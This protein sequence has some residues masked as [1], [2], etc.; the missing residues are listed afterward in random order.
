MGQPGEDPA[1]GGVAFADFH[2]DEE[3]A[4]EELWD[5]DESAAGDGGGGAEACE[6]E[7]ACEDGV[8]EEAV[9]E[10]GVWGEDWRG[11]GGW[12]GLWWFCEGVESPWW[13]GEGEGIGKV[14]HGWWWELLHFFLYVC[15]G[16]YYFYFY[17][18]DGSFGAHATNRDWDWPG[19]RYG[20]GGIVDF[21]VGLIGLSAWRVCCGG[22]KVLYSLFTYPK[23]S[24]EVDNCS[25]AARN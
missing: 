13:E 5:A 6:A 11:G 7:A 14:W 17:D 4:A 15:D 22:L 20:T 12:L 18:D 9:E 21:L 8:G 10:G 16:F 1:V 23:T 3:L 2:V 25:Y 24:R 19:G